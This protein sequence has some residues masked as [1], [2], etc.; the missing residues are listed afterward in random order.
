[1]KKIISS[2]VEFLCAL[3]TKKNLV[4]VS[5]GIRNLVMVG[6]EVKFYKLRTELATEEGVKKDFVALRNFLN[7]HLF[8]S[9]LVPPQ[10]T[11]FLNLLRSNN[12][13]SC[14]SW[15]PKHIALMGHIETIEFGR[16][17]YEIS[18][19]FQGMGSYAEQAYKKAVA[20]L[21]SNQNW[22]KKLKDPR[23]KAL[24]DCFNGHRCRYKDTSPDDNIVNHE[25]I[26]C[27]RH[28]CTHMREK[29]KQG[30]HVIDAILMDIV[31]KGV[32]RPKATRG[33]KA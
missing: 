9:S 21:G 19:T 6:G 11:E 10:M 25:M 31:I 18:N 8:A 17:F 1:M 13:R 7:M 23:C 12:I 3:H 32:R 30:S 27:W 24:Q 5:F 33:P 28:T 2:M 14:Q 22:T 20:R 29:L 15:L 16:R 26:K 4:A